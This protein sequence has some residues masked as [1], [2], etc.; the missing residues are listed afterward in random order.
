QPVAQLLIHPIAGSDLTR[1]SYGETL[2]AQPISLAGMQWRLRHALAEREQNRD[3]R[4]DLAARSDLAGVA[5]VTLILAEI[6]PL[7]S[8]G[9]ALA[10]ALDAAGVATS[11]TVYDGVTQGFFGL[12]LIVTKAL[13]AQSDAAEALSRALGP[14]RQS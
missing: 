4:I 6:D 11:C 8:E 13:F 12:G 7:R 5:P 14:G 1:A 10:E 2:Q 9:E 3:P